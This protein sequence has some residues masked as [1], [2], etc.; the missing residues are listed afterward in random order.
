MRWFDPFETGWRVGIYL[1]LE[2]YF[3]NHIP[4]KNNSQHFFFAKQLA[5]F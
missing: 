4:N 3:T 2:P 1:F 5:T